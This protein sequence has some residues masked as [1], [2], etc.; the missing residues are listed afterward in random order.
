M[1]III[2]EINFI[3]CVYVIECG[4]VNYE[5]QIMNSKV[6]SYNGRESAK[7]IINGEIKSKTLT[8][9]FKKEG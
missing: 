4:K 3:K 6:F 7:L 1:N 8:Y 9:N 2:N 5:L